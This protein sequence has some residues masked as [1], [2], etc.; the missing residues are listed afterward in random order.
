MMLRI[1]SLLPLLLCLFLVSVSP[2]LA[3]EDGLPYLDN[4]EESE[5]VLRPPKELLR[6]PGGRAELWDPEFKAL[7]VQ[8]T[9]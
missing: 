9:M 6:S 5:F 7:K 3:L 8:Y 2:A 4:A 1:L